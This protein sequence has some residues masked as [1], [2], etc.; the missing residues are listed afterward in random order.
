MFSVKPAGR[1]AR[2]MSKMNLGEVYSFILSSRR[3]V[4]LLVPAATLMELEEYIKAVATSGNAT[5]RIV[6]CSHVSHSGEL[7][8]DDVSLEEVFKEEAGE[9]SPL[10]QKSS[11]SPQE[12]RK[13]VLLFLAENGLRTNSRVERIFQLAELLE[14]H[15][16]S[17]T[18]GAVAEL[19]VRG[20]TLEKIKLA[21]TLLARSCSREGR[22]AIIFVRTRE[23]ARQLLTTR[24]PAEVKLLLSWLPANPP[25]PCEVDIITLRDVLQEAWGA[26]HGFLSEEVGPGYVAARC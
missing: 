19:I 15:E 4:A 24:V 25:R 3:P 10:L 14:E 22:P 7:C 12:M 20:C 21:I 18:C 13:K 26:F 9:F 1:Q 23:L 16:R 2:A 5:L 6:D 17:S 11:S 8:V